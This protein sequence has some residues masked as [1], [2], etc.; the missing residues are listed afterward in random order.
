MARVEG[1]LNT[2]GGCKERSVILIL[3][4]HLS[5]NATPK[6]QHSSLDMSSA[7]CMYQSE[8]DP[9]IYIE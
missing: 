9:G 6:R 1:D 3:P 2:I 4:T 7:A 5:P 8:G